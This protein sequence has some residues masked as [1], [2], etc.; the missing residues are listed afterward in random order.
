MQLFATVDKDGM[1]TSADVNVKNKI[2]KGTRDK[3][4]IWNPNNCECECGKSCSIGE[5]LN[6]KN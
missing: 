3:E 1:K 4:F 6:Y 5:Y 2:D